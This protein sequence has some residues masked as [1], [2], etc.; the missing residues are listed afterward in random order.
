MLN[1]PLQYTALLVIRQLTFHLNKI[2]IFILKF[3]NID[4]TKLTHVLPK[5]KSK[6]VKLYKQRTSFNSFSSSSAH[7]P[8]E[9]AHR[10]LPKISRRSILRYLRPETSRDLNQIVD[11]PGEDSAYQVP[12]SLWPPFGNLSVPMAVGFPRYIFCPLPLFLS[13]PSSKLFSYGCSNF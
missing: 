8:L 7:Q 4:Y 2:K 5:A 13:N 1:R 11:P 3:R 6:T 9:I 12:S 10:R